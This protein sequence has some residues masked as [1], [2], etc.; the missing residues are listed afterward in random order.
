LIKDNVGGVKYGKWDTLS[1][2]SPQLA[3]LIVTGYTLKPQ[4]NILD[5]FAGRGTRGLIAG[6]LNHNYES[7][8]G[9]KGMNWGEYGIIKPRLLGLFCR[10]GGAGIRW[11]ND[12][13]SNNR[14]A[15]T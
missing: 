10:S 13:K 6:F 8:N 2:F 11:K 12:S 9:V 7:R 3:E 14:C 4:S 15:K 1:E 5:P